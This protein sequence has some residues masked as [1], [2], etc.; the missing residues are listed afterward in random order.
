MNS[1]NAVVDPPSTV[2]ARVMLLDDDPT[3]IEVLKNYLQ[4]AGYTD[5]VATTDA[6]RAV[7]L[8]QQAAPDLLITDLMM[9]EV[10]GFEI[11]KK[12]R[13]DHRL[14]RI[15]IIVLTSSTNP[16]HKLHALE[17]GATDFL[18]KP[19]DPSELVLRLRNNLMIKTYQDQLQQAHLQS[20]RLLL[21]MLP[22]SVAE[23]LKRGETD[24][25]DYFDEATV[26][27]ADLVNFTDFASK[28]DATTAVQRLNQ[29]FKAFDQVVDARGLEKIKT[30]GDSYMLAGGLPQRRADHARAVIDAGLDMLT[31]VG[32]LGEQGGADFQLRVGAHTGPVVAGVIGTNKL[33]Y[34]L[35]GDT[36]NV[37][38]RMEST[39]VNGRLQISEATRQS[40]GDEFRVEAR[41][42]ID[43]KGKGTMDTFFVFRHGD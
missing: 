27:F 14:E 13:A 41:G 19:V 8:L 1:L 34:D 3:I 26:L 36:V 23:R 15:P 4:E 35:W 21:N 5:I 24:V 43:I 20:D 38:S 39:G 37:A 32:R 12:M 17:L 31:V 18:S 6:S 11:L 29:V 33:Y 28:T 30:I 7:S 25:A 16:E 2:A 22:A 10:D 9:P 40:L 42:A